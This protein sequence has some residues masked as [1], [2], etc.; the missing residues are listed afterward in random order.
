M[1]RFSVVKMSNKI[2]FNGKDLL[3]DN[4]IVNRES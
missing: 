1:T 3:L 4:I 2:I